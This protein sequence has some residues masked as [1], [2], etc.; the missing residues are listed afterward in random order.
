M[1]LI[2]KYIYNNLFPYN[3]HTVWIIV[4]VYLNSPNTSPFNSI[5]ETEQE[6]EISFNAIHFNLVKILLYG[7]CLGKRPV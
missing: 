3:H 7:K 6:E 5:T 2:N 1:L 4:F